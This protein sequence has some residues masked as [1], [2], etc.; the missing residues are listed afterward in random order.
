MAALLALFLGSYGV[1]HFYLGNTD[2]GVSYLVVGLILT[3]IY[4]LFGLVTVG[5]GYA[6]PLPLLFGIICI[7]DA[8]HYLQDDDA[9]FQERIAREKEP[10]W[11]KVMY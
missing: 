8:V 4:I 3:I 11:K 2:R 6:I 7:I 10:L 1:H 5:F 9:K